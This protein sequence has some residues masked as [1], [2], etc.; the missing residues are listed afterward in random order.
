[1]DRRHH[2]H[3]LPI[4]ITEIPGFKFGHFTNRAGG[5]GCTAIVAPEGAVGGADVR[6]GAGIA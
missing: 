6:G 1:M 2:V 3:A 4:S 5:T